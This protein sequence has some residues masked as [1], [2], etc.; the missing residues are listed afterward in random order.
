LRAGGFQGARLKGVFHAFT[1]TMSDAEKAVSMGF[2]LGI[3]GIVPL[4]LGARQI[5]SGIGMTT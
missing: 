4:K 5:V 3:G 2:M 1:G